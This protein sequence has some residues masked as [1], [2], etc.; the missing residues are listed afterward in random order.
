MSENTKPNLLINETSPYLLQHAHNPVNWYPWCDEAFKRAK[1][2]DKPIFLSI[3]YSTCHWCHVMAH[4]S[5]EDQ[6]VADILNTHF[7]CIKVDKEERPDIDSIYMAVC[8]AFTGSGGWPTSIF[9]TYEQKP[10]FAGTYFPKG[11]NYGMMGFIDLLDAIIQ[12]WQTNRHQLLET[13]EEVIRQLHAPAKKSES[14]DGMLIDEAVQLFEKGFDKTYGGFGNAPKFPMPHNLLFLMNYYGAKPDKSILEMIETTLLHM[15]KG[16]IFDHIGYGFSRYSTDRYF[17][18]PH[19]EK[20]LYDNALLLMSYTKAFELTEKEIYK[21]IAQKTAQYVLREMTSPE[22]GFYCAQDADSEGIEGKYYV[23]DYDEITR[24]LG[25]ETGKAFNAYYG[26]SEKGNFEGRNIPN[27][28]HHTN[29]DDRF[30]EC[31]PKLYKYRKSRAQLHLDDKILTSWNALMI[32]AFAEMYRVL[33]EETYLKAAEKADQ[34]ITENLQ[35]E[36]ALFVSFREGVRSSRGFLDDYAFYIFAL[37]KLYE[38]TLNTDYLNRAADLCR[39]TIE[40]FWDEENGGFYLY[41]KENQQLIIVPKETYDGAIPS[42]NSVMAYNLVKLSHIL[43]VREFMEKENQQLEFM[44]ASAKEYP[45]GYSFFLTALWMHLNPPEH[46]VCV[47]ADPADLGKIKGRRRHGVDIKVLEA[48]TAEYPL[49]NDKTTFYVCRNHSC[50]P[51][52]NEGTK[53]FEIKED[54]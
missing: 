2:E 15:Y 54:V 53:A 18:V 1:E 4:E 9:M 43:E 48:P 51:P 6:Q 47:L 14:I 13:S 45:A 12:N 20:M 7:V 46:M 27:L 16:G 36:D 29:M 10:F 52:T 5:F 35:E 38:A 49:I 39:K 40:E 42:G 30:R 33:G 41:G 32:A 11:S 24:L 17:L 8:Q 22:G 28:L 3:G 19:F 23:F 21:Q 26:I 34:F 37:I 31:L 50:L 44:S 25:E